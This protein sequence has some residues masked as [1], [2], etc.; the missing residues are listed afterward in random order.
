[1]Y[2]IKE[3]R[4]Y[5][6]VLGDVGRGNSDPSLCIFGERVTPN[7]HKMV[8]EFA[9][10]DNTYCNGILSA[11]GHEWST[12]AFSTDYVEKSYTG[13]PRS[14]PDGMGEDEAD[15][16]AYAPTGF[17]WDNALRHGKTLRDYGEFTAHTVRW[18]DPKKKGD[19]D[20]SACWREYQKPQGEILF[21]SAAVIESLKPYAAT[22]TL[23]WNL[24]VSD[25]F[26]A[27]AIL[28][29]LK[30]YEKTGTFPDLVLVCLP[31]DHTSGTRAGKP[32][33]AAYAADNDLAFGRIVEALSH[34]RFW[35]DMAVFSIEDDP[36]NGWDHVSG[37][38]T[39]AYIASPYVKRG[40]VV[41]TFY[42][43]VS[44]L[45][46]IENILGLP[47]MNQFDAAADPMFD[48][49][50]D[51]PDLRPFVAVPNRVRLDELN[52][53]PAKVKDKLIR[54]LAV[55]SGRLDF[56]RPDACPEETLNRILWHAVKGSAAPYP[57][58]ATAGRPD[59][60]D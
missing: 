33:P 7:Q 15:A 52:P 55:A 19:P 54:R 18:A 48:V 11:E 39:T 24:E 35:K 25:Q 41:S 27:D 32:T 46:T 51:T 58:W 21:G 50:T 13:W 56:S 49:F 14:Y 53:P 6:Q 5:D 43:T 20:W 44:L 28:K 16:L 17:I 26:R 34:S 36:Q 29:E 12:T 3:N 57:S 60:D 4:S 42:N 47:P 38:R 10:L 22:Q 8:R 2:I 45:R 23:G 31:D 1:V 37:Y 40:A 59:G 30:Q 9:L